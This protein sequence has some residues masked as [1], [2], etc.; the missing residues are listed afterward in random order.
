M[1]S[2]YLQH[3]RSGARMDGSSRECVP[4]LGRGGGRS[5]P[6]GV[7][8]VLSHVGHVS[9]R[10]RVSPSPLCWARFP[11][12]PPRFTRGHCPGGAGKCRSQ[13]SQRSR[14][15]A[16]PC[17]LRRGN[18]FAIGWWVR[19]WE[20]GHGAPSWCET[21]TQRLG[22]RAGTTCKVPIWWPWP[23]GGG[24]P[25][26]A[27]GASRPL[28]IPAA[29]W[30][31]NSGKWSRSNGKG[32]AGRPGTRRWEALQVRYDGGG[33][34][35]AR[36]GRSSPRDGRSGMGPGKHHHWPRLPRSCMWELAGKR[37]PCPG[38]S[39]GISSMAPLALRLL[40]G[41]HPNGTAL[42][43]R[44]WVRA[45]LSAARAM[46]WPT[47]LAGRRTTGHGAI[48]VSR[49][50]GTLPR[51]PAPARRGSPMRKSRTAMSMRSRRRW[52]LS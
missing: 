26:G 11:P 1:G 37:F 29:P 30:R 33:G 19:R 28:L 39:A 25:N 5:P 46:I 2:P 42:C 41:M 40:P 47:N 6:V 24:D 22:K 9:A 10:P 35:T 38:C 51:P 20:Q 3:C 36:G 16:G 8:V 14:S 49:S 18:K 13:I 45:Q 12:R 52:P 34:R 32:T 50:R 44:F 15:G 17:C 43:S 7:G 48:W 27:P 21:K 23:G 31:D 4:K